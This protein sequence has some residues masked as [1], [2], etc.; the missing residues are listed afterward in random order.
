[1]KY[2]GMEKLNKKP[3]RV[4]KELSK[5]MRLYFLE[6]IDEEL[7]LLFPHCIFPKGE[8]IGNGCYHIKKQAGFS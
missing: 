1:M 3:A 2:Q 4:D 8:P 6:K 5:S 7:S